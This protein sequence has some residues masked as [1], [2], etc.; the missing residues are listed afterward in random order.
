MNWRIFLAH[1][2]N[3]SL[4]RLPK[5]DRSR[6]E[7]ATEAMKINPYTGDVERLK[8]EKDTWRRRIGSYRIFFEV[9]LAD[10]MYLP[11]QASEFKNLLNL[12]PNASAVRGRRGGCGGGDVWLI[13]GRRPEALGPRFWP[14]RPSANF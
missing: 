6:V 8:G 14:P 9:F 2:A 1:D 5:K 10:K 13:P 11:N 4:R 7:E 12:T 3:K